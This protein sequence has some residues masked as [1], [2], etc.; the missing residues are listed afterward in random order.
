MKGFPL[1]VAV[2]LTPSHDIYIYNRLD[3]QVVQTNI[4][5]LL[6]ITALCGQRI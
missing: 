3:I 1:P 2:T 6:T 5:L 4:M